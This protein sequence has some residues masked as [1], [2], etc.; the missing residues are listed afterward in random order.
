MKNKLNAVML[1]DDNDDDNFFHAHIIRKSDITENILVAT[2][3]FEALEHLS[4]FEQAPQLIFLDINMPKM[5]G[6]DFLEAYKKMKPAN[7]SIVI[8][9][10]TTSLNPIDREKAVQNEMITDFRTKPLTREMLLE[11]TD[12]YFL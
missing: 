6:F 2:S 7:K 3:A 10:L 4:T 8:V 1:I 11:I 9:M 5:N 12:R